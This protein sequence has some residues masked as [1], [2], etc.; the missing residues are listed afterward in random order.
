MNFPSWPLLCLLWE[1]RTPPAE[2]RT[3]KVSSLYPKMQVLQQEYRWSLK[4]YG[5][6]Y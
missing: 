4:G 2:R 1:V 6:I 3:T 5:T